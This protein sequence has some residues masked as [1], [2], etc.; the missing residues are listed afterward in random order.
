MTY[1]VTFYCPDT[2]LVYNLHTLDKQGI[3]GGVTAR[4]RMA[5][6]LAELGHRVTIYNNCPKKQ[7][8]DNVHYIPHQQAERI[9]SDIFIASTSGDG[10]DLSRVDEIDLHAKLSILMVHGMYPPNGIDLEFFDYI[11]TLS[12]FVRDR[13]ENQWEINLRKLLTA[14]RGVKEDHYHRLGGNILKR[15]PLG[16]IYSGHPSKGLDPAIKILKL[17]TSIEPGFSLHVYGGY[18]LCGEKEKIIDAVPN[19]TYHGLIGQRELAHEM[20][21]YSY[22]LNIQDMED[23]FGISIIEAMRAGCIVLASSVGAFPEIIQNGS[24][25]FLVKGKSND[26]STHQI[27]SQ[28]IMDLAKNEGYSK[29]IR[30]NAIASPNNWRTVAKA[31]EGH[32][33]WNLTDNSQVKPIEGLGTCPSCESDLLPLADGIHCIGCGRYQKSLGL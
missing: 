29:Y 27:A 2:H 18:S 32:W 3:G 21:R 24:N 12:N 1:S 19:V 26:K 13:I 33:E 23:T 11:Y 7:N 25:G 28:L 6:A 4:I 31:W 9:D 17:L 15:D 20:Q 14:H 5:H 10:L 22:A 8:I 16:I 30:K